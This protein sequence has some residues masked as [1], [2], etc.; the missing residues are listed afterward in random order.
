MSKFFKSV[1]SDIAGAAVVVASQLTLTDLVHSIT[2]GKI[3]AV[4]GTIIGGALIGA[5]RGTG[6]GGA[7]K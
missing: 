2:S 5:G 3:L 6:D 4:V 1:W 7:A